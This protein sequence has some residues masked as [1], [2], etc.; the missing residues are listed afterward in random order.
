MAR[1]RNSGKTKADVV[2]SQIA[3]LMQNEAIN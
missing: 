2:P 1:K 3:P